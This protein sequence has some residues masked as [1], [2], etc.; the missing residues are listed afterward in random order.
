MQP[1]SFRG[2]RTTLHSRKRQLSTEWIIQE[3]RMVDNSSLKGNSTNSHARGHRMIGEDPQ[4]TGAH[5]AKQKGR[6]DTM[7]PISRN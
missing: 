4:I 2:C 3:T 7:R 6:I 1:P 5:G